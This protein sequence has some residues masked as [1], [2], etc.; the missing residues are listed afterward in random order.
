MQDTAPALNQD[1]LI[2]DGAFRY[3]VRGF[4]KTRWFDF[5]LLDGFTLLAFSSAVEPLRIANQIAG[6]PLYGWNIVSEEDTSVGSSSGISLEVQGA[7]QDVDVNA[8]LFV[9]SGNQGV[10]CH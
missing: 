6:E 2:P 4:E 3:K 9:C 8:Y 10:E 1:P 5:L 7:L